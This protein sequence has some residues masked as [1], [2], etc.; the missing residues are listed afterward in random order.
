MKTK[1]NTN[2]KVNPFAVAREAINEA[3]GS[4]IGELHCTI[5][6]ELKGDALKQMYQAI[7]PKIDEIEKRHDELR[8]R[9]D[10]QGQH[11]LAV[12]FDDV[13]GDLAIVW[14]DAAFVLGI[15]FA[16]RLKGEPWSPT[17]ATEN[18]SA[19]SATLI[20][21]TQKT[22][23]EFRIGHEAPKRKH[24]KDRIDALVDNLDKYYFRISSAYNILSHSEWDYPK[25]AC[26]SVRILF[27]DSPKLKE[28]RDLFYD[29]VKEAEE[30]LPGMYAALEEAAL[31]WQN[32]EE[33]FPM[34]LGYVIG[35]RIAGIPSE[36]T[37]RMAR[38]WRLG[39]PQDDSA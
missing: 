25:D 7:N 26:D 15:A 22:N 16:Q 28:A 35:L 19:R 31:G 30:K 34:L 36:Q 39:Y 38:T 8:A 12:D 2:G 18:Q 27:Q 37:K 21:E 13:W 3:Y 24:P 1:S 33:H 17:L 6:N 20:G 14:Q 9:A 4:Q 5:Q 11:K 10:K 23:T 32:E 29:N